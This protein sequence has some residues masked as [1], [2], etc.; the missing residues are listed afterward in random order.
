VAPQVWEM[1]VTASALLW[2]SQRKCIGSD[3]KET[4]NIQ[5]K[6]CF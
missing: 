4:E 6:I 3:D 1:L 2:L 5:L